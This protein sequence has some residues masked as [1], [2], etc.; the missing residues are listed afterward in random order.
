MSIVQAISV[1][2]NLGSFLQPALNQAHSQVS[3]LV[4][5]K[6]FVFITCLKHFPGHT[7]FGRG[8]PLPRG[9]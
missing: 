6:I 4:G 3:G 2:Q 7:Q 5:Q 8:Q 1:L 9:H